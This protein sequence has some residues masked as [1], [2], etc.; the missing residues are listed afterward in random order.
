MDGS[1]FNTFHFHFTEDI[2]WWLAI[3]QYPQLTAPENMLRDKGLY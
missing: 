1:K 2:A 3:K